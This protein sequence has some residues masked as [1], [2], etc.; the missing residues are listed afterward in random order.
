VQLELDIEMARDGKSVRADTDCMYMLHATC[1]MPDYESF[2]TRTVR[3]D[4]RNTSTGLVVGGGGAGPL[5]IG[6]VIKPDK[7]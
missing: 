1:Y 7:P 3:V 2:V 4:G 6:G 5:E